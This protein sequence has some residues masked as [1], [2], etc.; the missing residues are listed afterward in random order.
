MLISQRML[1]NLYGLIEIAKYVAPQSA[2]FH[3]TYRFDSRV[4]LEILHHSTTQEGLGRTT[5]ISSNSV[6][7]GRALLPRAI[8]IG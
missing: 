6:L 1:V 7:R 2:N 5:A 8:I 3:K 4:Q